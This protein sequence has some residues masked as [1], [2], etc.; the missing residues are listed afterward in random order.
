MPCV[1]ACIGKKVTYFYSLLQDS[2]SHNG[3]RERSLEAKSP[4][5]LDPPKKAKVDHPEFPG[6][7]GNDP[8]GLLLYQTWAAAA[9]KAAGGPHLHPAAAAAAAWSSHYAQAIKVKFM[10]S[11]FPYAQK[12]CAGVS[13]PDFLS[14]SR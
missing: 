14:R 3:G 8:Y 2:A 5:H 10:P 9:G 11:S 12:R 7:S 1:V 6:G 13:C 4:R